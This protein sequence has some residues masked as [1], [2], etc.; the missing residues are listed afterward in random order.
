MTGGYG[1]MRQR[2]AVAVAA[3]LAA[4]VVTGGYG[5]GGGLRIWSDFVPVLILPLRRR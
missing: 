3:A 4:T 2:Q 5:G 1:N